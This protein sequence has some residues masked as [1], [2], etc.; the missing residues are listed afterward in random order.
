MILRKYKP[1]WLIF[2]LIKLFNLNGI[3]QYLIVKKGSSSCWYLFLHMN[4]E[5][6]MNRENIINNDEKSITKKCYYHFVQ[7]SAGSTF[8]TPNNSN[9]SMVQLP[10]K[11]HG[12]SLFQSYKSLLKP[13]KKPALTV[14]PFILTAIR[15]TIKSLWFKVHSKLMK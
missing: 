1:L 8:S 7:S 10:Y 13:S 9:P 14:L 6:Y 3:S 11:Q 12:Y 15:P 5:I 2:N 4:M